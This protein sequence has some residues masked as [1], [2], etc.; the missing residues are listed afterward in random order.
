MAQAFRNAM[1]MLG[2][3]MMDASRMESGNPAKFLRLEQETGAILPGLRADLVHLD[4]QR[5]VRRSWIAGDIS[6]QGE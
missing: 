3:S 5:R 1:D 2:C 4:V 6:E